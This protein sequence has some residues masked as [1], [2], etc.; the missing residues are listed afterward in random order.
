VW[1]NNRCEKV[2][3]HCMLKEMNECTDT[4]LWNGDE[5]IFFFSFSFFDNL[6]K[7]IIII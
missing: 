1:L 3:D 2:T 5:S 6:K 7:S 4:C